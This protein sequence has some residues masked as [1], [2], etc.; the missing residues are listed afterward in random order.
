MNEGRCFLFSRENKIRANRGE[1]EGV[2]HKAT[3]KV[4]SAKYAE[5]RRRIYTKKVLKQQKLIF[6]F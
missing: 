1:K 5:K 4:I 3:Q 6:S 2:N